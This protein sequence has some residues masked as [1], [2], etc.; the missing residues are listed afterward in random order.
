MDGQEG[1]HNQRDYGVGQHVE[2]RQTADQDDV[3]VVHPQHVPQEVDD[4]SG[5]HN[6]QDEEGHPVE[7]PLEHRVEWEAD[8]HLHEADQ[9]GAL[10]ADAHVEGEVLV[11]GEQVEAD[12]ESAETAG[13][14]VGQA[15]HSGFAVDV[16]QT[17]LRAKALASALELLQVQELLEDHHDGHD[18]C[19]RDQGEQLLQ[20]GPD[21]VLH[22]DD[23]ELAVDPLVEAEVLEAE[24]VVFPVDGDADDDEDGDEGDLVEFVAEDEEDEDGADGEAKGEDV[25]LGEGEFD[26]FEGAGEG[27]FLGGDEEGIEVLDGE[28]EELLKEGVTLTRAMRAIPKTMLA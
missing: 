15:Q 11:G 4:G 3:A 26:D 22:V 1:R 17:A 23:V 28:G 21:Q 9:L 27:V 8:E 18:K 19:G 12:G 6:E 25:E 5:H 16:A 10:V 2:G 14:D 20:S 24:E 13:N 7:E